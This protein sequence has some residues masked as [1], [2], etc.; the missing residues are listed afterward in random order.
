MPRADKPIVRRLEDGRTRVLI[1]RY[2]DPG[3]LDPDGVVEGARMPT[4]RYT[5]GAM[6]RPLMPTWM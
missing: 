5:M 6:A 3:F 1:Q 4:A 2:D